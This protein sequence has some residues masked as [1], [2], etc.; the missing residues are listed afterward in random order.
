M[1]DIVFPAAPGEG[2]GLPDSTLFIAHRGGFGH[3]FSFL[4]TPSLVCRSGGSPGKII[5]ASFIVYSPDLRIE[6][7]VAFWNFDA[8]CHLV[9]LIRPGIGFLSVKPRF[10]YRF[11]SPERHHSKLAGRYGARRQLRPVWTFI[12]D[13]KE[14]GEKDTARLHCLFS[15]TRNAQPTGQLQKQVSKHN[16]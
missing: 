14:G 7:T 1:A 11:F 3:P 9:R 13:K 8:F 16:K 12:T 2:T 4:S 5:H 15:Q 6:V 10:R